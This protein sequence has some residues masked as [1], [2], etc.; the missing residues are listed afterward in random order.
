MIIPASPKDLGL[1]PKLYPSWRPYQL[2]A[3][4]DTLKS[5]ETTDL[6]ALDMPVGTGKTL[7]AL[8][9]ARMFAEKYQDS[10]D[11]RV[12]ILTG[13][14]GLMD[15]YGK[16]TEGSKYRPFDIRGAGN[17]N[18]LALNNKEF[19]VQIIRKFHTTPYSA[20]CDHGPCL[21]KIECPR[22]EHGCKFYGTGALGQAK[23]SNFLITNY[24]MWLMKVL[25]NA[26]L[27][28]ADEGHLLE[29]EIDKASKI[30]HPNMPFT[31]IKDAQE[32]AAKRSAYL[33]DRELTLSTR[34]EL[35]VAKKLLG[36][37]NPENWRYIEGDASNSGWAP[38]T[39][40]D[41]GDILANSSDKFVVMSGTMSRTDI[42]RFRQ[43]IKSRQLSWTFKSYP[44]QFPVNNRRLY[45]YPLKYNGKNVGVTYK[46][47]PIQ[48]QL[49]LDHQ[50]KIV[51]R[52][53]LSG[54]GIIHSVSYDRAKKIR[55]ALVASGIQRPIYFP[56]NARQINT[57]LQEYKL[58]TNGGILISP[59][60]TTGFDFHGE[61]CRWQLIMKMP[62]A[63]TMNPIVKARCEMDP[64]YSL[65]Y[66]LKTLDQMIGRGV[67]SREDWC[68]TWITDV[69][70]S[71]AVF[72]EDS[73]GNHLA[74]ER[75]RESFVMMTDDVF[76]TMKVR[77]S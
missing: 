33:A 30:Y 44:S 15:Q 54:K 52:A 36:I 69:N 58:S 61:L 11:N 23:V 20:K 37:T 51:K 50:V 18:C 8:A 22:K 73:S 10:G 53:V 6:V 59:S 65:T 66:A 24:S 42:S 21:V 4:V 47:T 43:S 31:S 25:G 34:N 35:R 14:K 19:P 26:R 13:T 5:L 2:E 56:E 27:V 64:N 45:C 28:I 62:F 48:E 39:Y 68:E 17:Y 72:S 12:V 9:I 29:S 70:A 1:N 49:L 57:V 75:L 77:V 71:W 60:I 40:S 41:E 38:I 63:N 3:I 74:P 67:R 16:D 7:V 55:A 46:L 32:W 76:N